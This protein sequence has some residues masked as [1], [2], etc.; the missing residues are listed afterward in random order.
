MSKLTVE[1]ITKDPPGS[2][3]EIGLNERKPLES[4]YFL[5]DKLLQIYS[6]KS[7]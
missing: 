1:L 6:N 2:E 5:N 4:Q 7:C 3:N